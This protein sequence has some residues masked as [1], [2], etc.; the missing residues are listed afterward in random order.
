MNGLVLDRATGID[1]LTLAQRL[2]AAQVETRPFFLGMHRQ[3]VLL[4]RGLFAGESYPVADEL[5][6]QG[7]YL[8]SGVGLSDAEIATVLAATEACAR[9]TDVFGQ[10]YAAAYDLLYADKDYDAECDLLE[11]IFRES[12]R[13]V[14]TVL[15]LGCGT[16][17]HAVRLA[18]RGYEVVGVDLSE[19][20]LRIARDR[21]R[22]VPRLDVEL[23]PGRMSARSTSAARS[24][25]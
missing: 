10:E 18:Q 17:A 14:R 13:P 9:M 16:G 12:G 11:R 20:M 24:T 6:D 21:A 19:D 3:P 7:L 4:E 5:A 8:P 15:D 22:S 23:R 2:S 1:A 25:R